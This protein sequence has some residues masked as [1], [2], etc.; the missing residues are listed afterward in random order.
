[1]AECPFEQRKLLIDSI[2]DGQLMVLRE[3]VVNMLEKNLP[4]PDEYRS[5]LNNRISLMRLL[6]ESGSEEEKRVKLRKNSHIVKH[7][8]T[9]ARKNG[10][11]E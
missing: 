7:V 11:L 5:V 10:S 8:C 9:I 3:L 4:C 2:T 1:M 6:A